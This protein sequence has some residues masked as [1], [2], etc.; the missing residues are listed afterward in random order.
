VNAKW[1][2][3]LLAGYVA[4]GTQAPEN[5]FLFE[6]FNETWKGT[7]SGWGLWDETRTPLYGL[8][9]TAVPSAPVCSSPIY[10]GAGYDH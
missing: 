7:D 3:D 10:T 6:A 9:G 8:C 5:V 1:Y 2:A 4:G